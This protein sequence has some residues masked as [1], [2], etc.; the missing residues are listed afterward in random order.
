M[1]VRSAHLV[2]QIRCRALDLTIDWVNCLT[3][4]VTRQPE[5]D[6]EKDPMKAAVKWSGIT[7]TI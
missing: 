3:H 4:V 7:I 1:R 2:V 5:K 6:P